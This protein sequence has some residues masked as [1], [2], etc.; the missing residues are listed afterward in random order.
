VQ[1]FYTPVGTAGA[2]DNIW[3]ANP[4]FFEGIDMPNF[5]VERTIAEEYA[6]CQRYYEKSYNDATIVPTGGSNFGYIMTP[7][8]TAALANASVLASVRFRVVKRA[9]P[10]VNVYSFTAATANKVSDGN[11]VDLAANS[12][13][14][15]SVGTG[16][17]QVQNASGGTVT[18]ALNALIFHFAADCELV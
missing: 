1:I 5:G 9:A 12:G 8:G 13:V 18:P 6:L 3:I 7:A 11:G 2:A 15:I 4:R 16:G 10:T 17:F 14:P